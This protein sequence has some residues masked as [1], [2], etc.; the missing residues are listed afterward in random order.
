MKKYIYGLVSLLLLLTLCSCTAGTITQTVPNSTSPITQYKKKEQQ[1]QAIVFKEYNQDAVNLA[2]NERK[3]I[4]LYIHSENCPA[5]V[6]TEKHL[7]VEKEIISVI[8][9]YFISSIIDIE[10]E[11]QS[12]IAFSIMKT[13]GNGSIPLFIMFNPYNMNNLEPMQFTHFSGYSSAPS[14]LMKIN[15]SLQV[16]KQLEIL[17]NIS[18]FKFMF[19]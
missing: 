13:I 10:K 2:R 5:C 18:E 1:N 19:A 6:L 3:L 8:N 14:F 16:L 7:F 4:L 11:G 15:I 9:Q 12:E 17:N